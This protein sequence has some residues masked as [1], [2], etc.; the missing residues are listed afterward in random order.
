VQSGDALVIPARAYNAFVDAARAHRQR[1]ADGGRGAGQGHP[2]PLLIPIKNS[3]G[4]VPR[5]G[6]LGISG[7]LF[8]PGSDLAAFQR[9]VVIDG[10]T[11][12]EADHAG[13]FAI[14]AEPIAA[15]RIGRAC[16]VGV[17]PVQVNIS[18]PTHTYA[19]VF[20][21]EV[22]RLASAAGTGAQILWKPTGTGDQW[23]LVRLPGGGG[24]ASLPEPGMH[25]QVLQLD[26]SLEPVWDWVRAHD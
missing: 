2:N 23:T 25:R 17:C 5:F 24:E 7:P 4:D 11:P 8:D 3:G 22:T 19:D 16:L 10:T 14:T 15:G 13:C 9:G 12:T 20:D 6:V 18:D 1:M 21:G 26:M